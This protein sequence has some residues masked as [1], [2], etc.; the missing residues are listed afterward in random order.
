[1]P[2][3]Q[4]RH[5]E[6]LAEFNHGDQLVRRGDRFHATDIDADHYIGA[7]RAV[8]VPAA[9]PAPA[10]PAPIAKRVARGASATP[11]AADTSAAAEADDGELAAGF[12]MSDSAGQ[13]AS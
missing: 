3:Y 8:E 2:H 4:T 5:L 11:P 12:S 7:K 13:A 6:A 9:P 10:T 1:M